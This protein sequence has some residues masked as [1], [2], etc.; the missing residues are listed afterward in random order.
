M[1]KVSTLTEVREEMLSRFGGLDPG[2]EMVPLARSSGRYLSA[3][4]RA[5]GEVPPFSRSSKDGYAVRAGETAGAGEAMPALFHLLPD[6]E[7]GKGYDHLVGPGQAAYVPTGGIIPAGADAVVMVEYA[8][9]LGRDEVALGKPVAPGES[10]ISAGQ[11]MSVGEIVLPRGQRLRPADLGVL[12]ACGHTEAEV[13]RRP[14]MALF[15]SGDELKELGE[16]LEPGQIRDINLLTVAAEAEQLGFEVVRGGIIPD[17]EALFTETLRAAMGKADMVAVSGGSSAGK[18]D[19]TSRVFDSLGKPGT[20]VHG[21]A[22]NPGKPTVLGDADGFPLVGLPGHPVSA[23]LV[24]RILAP[25]FL[26]LFHGTLPVP[27][28]SVS[29][30][31]DENVHAAPGRDTYKPVFLTSSDEGWLARPVPGDSGMITVLSRARGYIHIPLES[32]GL[33]R[34]SRVDVFLL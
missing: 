8:E 6:V 21:I 7:M 13:F 18:K 32:E 17:D 26:S 27:A 3:D 19:Y 30:I 15:S 4:V 33:S 2:T 9:L 12:A 14:R 22:F 29:A 23:Y 11:D 25:L 5:L 28:P 24:F 31:L 34:G 10:F 20:F 16:T 1:L